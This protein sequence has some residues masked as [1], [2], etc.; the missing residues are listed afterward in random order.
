[1]AKKP[2]HMSGPVQR[3]KAETAPPGCEAERHDLTVDGVVMGFVTKEWDN[4]EFI[5]YRVVPQAPVVMKD[6]KEYH[7]KL[8]RAKYWLAVATG[9]ISLEDFRGQQ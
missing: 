2:A 6:W 4:Q 5:G 9:V 3:W 1:M 7:E 8:P